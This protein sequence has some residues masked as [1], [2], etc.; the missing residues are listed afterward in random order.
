MFERAI[1]RTKKE[2]LNLGLH[3][4]IQRGKIE[5][6]QIGKVEGMQKGKRQGIQIGKVEGIRFLVS[7]GYLTKEAAQEAIQKLQEAEQKG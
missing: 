7:Q 6:M 3:E 4:G 5:G 1:E 2:F